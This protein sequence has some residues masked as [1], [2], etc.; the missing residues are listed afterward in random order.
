MVYLP[1]QEKTLIFL[2]VPVVK[3]LADAYHVDFLEAMERLQIIHD[4][5]S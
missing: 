5:L 4:E 1:G 3:I 2:S